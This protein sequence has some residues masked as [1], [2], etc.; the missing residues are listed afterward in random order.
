MTQDSFSRRCREETDRHY[1][2]ID[3][4]VSDLGVPT[5]EVTRYYFAILEELKRDITAR[6]FL[7][8]LAS[9]RVKERLLRQRSADIPVRPLCRVDY[10]R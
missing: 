2:A 10:L 9:I 8:L 6:A 4:L 1:R 7:L 3:K 5:E